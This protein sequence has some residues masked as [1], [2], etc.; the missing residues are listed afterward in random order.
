MKKPL[1]FL[2][3]SLFFIPIVLAQSGTEDVIF[4]KNGGILRG[5]ILEIAS[6]STVRIQTAGGNVWV[7]RMSEV[8]KITEETISSATYYK[9]SGYINHTGIDVL[10]GSSSTT[11]RFQMMNGYRFSPRFAT[12]IGLGFIPYNDP[13]ALI[14]VYLDFS[15]NLLE[16]NTAP[17]LFLKTGY[18]FSV[19][20]EDNYPVEDHRGGW[21]FNPGI[22]LQFNHSGGFRWY[23]NAGYNINKARFSEQGW[24]NETIENELRYRR[25]I[26][27]LGF[28]F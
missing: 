24:G 18:N 17:Y 11:V 8:D 20:A 16:A 6:D 5:E 3:C 23:M 13:L 1:L 28:S 9:T 7:F 25:I 19:H 4:L 27:G 22:G 14:P 15:Y 12:G 2:I 10:S 21:M 26:F